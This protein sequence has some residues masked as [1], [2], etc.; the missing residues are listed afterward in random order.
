MDK[1]REQFQSTYGRAPQGA[2]SAP[3]RVNLIGEHT[4][5]NGG[6]VLPIAIERRT[7]ALWAGRDDSTL[8]FQSLASGTGILPVRTTG[9]PPVETAH[10]RGRMPRQ[11]TGKMPV[12]LA[13]DLAKPIAPLG[14]PKWA[15]YV[16]GV[17]ACLLERGVRLRGA[18][19]LI[20][21]DVPLGGGLSSSASLEVAVAMALLAAAGASGAIPPRELALL[22]QRAENVYAGAPCGIMDQSIAVMGRPGRALLLDCRSGDTQQVPFDDPDTVLLVADTQVKHDI[23]DGGYPLRR[24]QCE[25][26]ARAMGVKLLR[27]ADLAAIEEAQ[28]SGKLDARQA[29]RARHVVAEIARTLAAVEALK[30]RD[31]RLLGELMYGSHTS[32]RDDFEVSCE[33]LDTVVELSRACKGVHGARMTGGG[34]GGCAI[35]LC[36]AD[37]APAACEAVSGG[38][39]RRFGRRCPIFAT[40]AAGGAA[41]IP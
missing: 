8:N 9:V 38:F 41:E 30:R 15:N 23:G 11:L 21:G 35:I 29:Q 10:G 26:A 14:E 4:D 33:E 25:Q 5:Y 18:D 7:V 16:K 36:R 3:G 2:A 39:E 22:C 28:L 40:A 17:A 37:S 1:L 27:E 19:L 12:P 31:M 32:L 34:F 20:A 24:R 6:F 13:V